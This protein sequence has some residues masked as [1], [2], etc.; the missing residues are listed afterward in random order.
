[1]LW[2]GVLSGSKLPSLKP[3][4]KVVFALYI[5]AMV[6]VFSL[7][8][9]LM[10]K[11]LPTLVGTTWDALLVQ[12]EEFSHPQRYGIVLGK[13]LSALQLVL[14]SLPLLATLYLLYNSA[15]IPLRKLFQ[16]GKQ[17]TSR[18]IA[19]GLVVAGVLALV[20][21]LWV[22]QLPPMPVGIQSF[23]I[24]ERA[25]VETPV[26]Y[27][28]IPPVGGNHAPIWQNCG[29]YSAPVANENAVH[30]LE[31]GAVWITY[32][33]DLSAD[34]VDLLRQL[35]ARQTFVLVSPHPGPV[36]TGGGLRLGPSVAPRLGHRPPTRPVR[37]GLPPRPTGTRARR[38]LY[39]RDGATEV[40]SVAGSAS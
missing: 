27:G 24:T 18:A 21:Y 17:G 39:R 7:F 38:T 28:Q 9:F 22:L 2:R 5:L 37:A 14:A 11:G 34:Q 25:H 1:M 12:Q 36:R 40:T 15:R 33:P 4:V 13:I 6:P 19:A 16:W 32:R 8:L 29:F 26:L 23:A 35:A 30:S 20:A 3:W 10:V 31:H